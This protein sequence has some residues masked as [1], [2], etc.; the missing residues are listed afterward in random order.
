MDTATR[1]AL[2]LRLRPVPAPYPALVYLKLYAYMNAHAVR[3]RS[4]SAR[5]SALASVAALDRFGLVG[6]Q[7]AVI[8]ID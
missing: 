8:V 7:P 1:G 5:C 4:F 6:L 2:S 3:Y